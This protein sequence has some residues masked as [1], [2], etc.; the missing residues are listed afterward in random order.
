MRYAKRGL[1]QLML[2][3]NIKLDYMKD[4]FFSTG[5]HE[6]DISADI[7]RFFIADAIQYLYP[8]AIATIYGQSFSDEFKM[9]QIDSLKV[10]G[11]LESYILDTIPFNEG[12]SQVIIRFMSPSF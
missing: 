6:D 10:E 5:V 9:L 1:H 7:S 3:R 2:Q 8:K 11:P 4:N 12:T